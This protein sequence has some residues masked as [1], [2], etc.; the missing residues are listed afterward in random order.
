M[1]HMYACCQEEPETSDTKRLLVPLGYVRAANLEEAWE[2][3][4]RQWPDCNNVERFDG[5]L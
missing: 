3:A 4:K 5:V 1:G 2:K